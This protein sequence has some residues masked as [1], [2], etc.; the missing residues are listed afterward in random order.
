[1]TRSN[2]EEALRS[3]YRQRNPECELSPRLQTLC[4]ALIQGTTARQP[5]HTHHI[6]HLGGRPDLWSNLITLSAAL[7]PV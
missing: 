2:P 4:P 6:F 1:M 7:H 5:T 3:R